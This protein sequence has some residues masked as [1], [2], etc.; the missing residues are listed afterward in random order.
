MKNSSSRRDFI[1]NSAKLGVA[2]G[3]VASLPLGAFAQN[4]GANSNSNLT[5]KIRLK[6]HK[7]NRWHKR[8]H[9][10]G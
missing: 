6:Q 7:F 1:A 4:T 8:S 10:A 5:K 9:N 3:A 2:L